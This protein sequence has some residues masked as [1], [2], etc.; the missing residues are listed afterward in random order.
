MAIV[1]KKGKPDLFITFTCNPKWD[2]ITNALLPGQVAQDRPN[3]IA[4]VFYK[5]HKDMI[6]LL[7]KSSLFSKVSGYVSVIEF[8]KRGLPHAHILLI[9]ENECKPHEI[10]HY[11]KLVCAKF[12]DE[13]MFPELYKIINQCDIH[14]PCGP[15]N[16]S[17][18]CMVDGQCKY[19]YPRSFSESTILDVN[20]YPTYMRR[21][22]GNSIQVRG[23]VLDCRWIVPYNPFLTMRY[24]AHINTEVC[25]IITVVKYLYKYVYKGHDRA[26]IQLQVA[27]YKWG[28]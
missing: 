23:N 15:F 13:D 5:K 20:G 7:T 21:N 26:T 14:G 11:D 18:P 1:R 12:L 24:K 22:D 6:H 17:A 19:R 28:Y 10:A 3:L 4:R 8:Q 9:L 2:E 25:S 27:R 16:A